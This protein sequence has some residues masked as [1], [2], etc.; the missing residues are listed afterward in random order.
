MGCDL[1]WQV[2]S[3]RHPVLHLSAS[4]INNGPAKG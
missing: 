2:G 1:D 4:S 3:L